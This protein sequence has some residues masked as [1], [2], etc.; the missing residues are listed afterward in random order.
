MVAPLWTFLLVLVKLKQVGGEEENRIHLVRLFKT[1]RL[2]NRNV[3]K[4]FRRFMMELF[5]YGNV[6]AE[7]RQL[8][9]TALVASWLQMTATLEGIENSGDIK[10]HLNWSIALWRRGRGEEVGGLKA[11][12]RHS[13][14]EYD[15]V[16]GLCAW[17]QSSIHPERRWSCGMKTRRRKR[18]K[19]RRIGYYGLMNTERRVP[20]HTKKI[21]SEGK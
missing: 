19:E 4:L 2:L 9:C 6:D 13:S 12:A 21:D 3:V 7:L 16:E 14:F 11:Y 10:I 8:N 20:S 17:I 18:R 1:W 5:I 15:P